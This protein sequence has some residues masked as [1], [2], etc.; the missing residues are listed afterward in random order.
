MLENEWVDH[1]QHPSSEQ[2]LHFEDIVD[3]IVIEDEE[4]I[5]T[6]VIDPTVDLDADMPEVPR[7][8]QR[9]SSD[10]PE[11]GTQP[12]KPRF[13]SPSN[14]ELPSTSEHKNNQKELL[15]TYLNLLKKNFDGLLSYQKTSRK[16]YTLMATQAIYVV[17]NMT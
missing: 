13:T 17:S 10:S 6:Q 12:K 15:S 8:K 1:Y 7:R 9:K 16:S 5:I 4:L 2:E 14:M 3:D 11:I